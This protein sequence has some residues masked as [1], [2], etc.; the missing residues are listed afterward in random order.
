VATAWA[1]AHKDVVRGYVDAFNTSVAWFDDTKN[2]DKAMAD[3]IVHT[4]QQPEMVA[5][6][7]DFFRKIQ[8]FEPTGKVSL[9]LLANIVAALQAQGAVDKSFDPKRLVDPGLSVLAPE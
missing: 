3:L 9:K 5:T 4:K 1:N 7:Y 2:R 6:T 8:Y